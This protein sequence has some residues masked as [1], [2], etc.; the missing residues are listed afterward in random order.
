MLPGLGRKLPALLGSAS[1]ITRDGI[2]QDALRHLIGAF[3]RY[4]GNLAR[5]TMQAAGRERSD[6]L[7]QRLFIPLLDWLRQRVMLKEPAN[8]RRT[9]GHLRSPLS[10]QPLIDYSSGKLYP[11]YGL[12]FTTFE[13]R[14]TG[15]W[16]SWQSQVYA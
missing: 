11:I 16:R 6:R 12:C 14:C 10:H 9:G 1:T 5:P 15:L 4:L 3:R 7:L 13:H 2:L 8:R